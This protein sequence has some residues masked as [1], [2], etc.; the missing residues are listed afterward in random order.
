[1]KCQLV[2]RQQK[3]KYKPAWLATQDRKPAMR[4]QATQQVMPGIMGKHREA[5]G[6][7]TGQET[8]ACGQE[9]GQETSVAEPDPVGSE[10]FGRIRS[11]TEINVS[12]PDSKLDI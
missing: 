12:D 7:E 8:P 5:L 4:G 10:P 3:R 1:M 11:R 9:T 6:Q 2:D